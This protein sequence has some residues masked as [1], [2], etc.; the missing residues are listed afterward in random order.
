MKKDNPAIILNTKNPETLEPWWDEYSIPFNTA[1]TIADDEQYHSHKFFEI[2]FVESGKIKHLIEQEQDVLSE[3]DI[4]IIS[5]GIYHG[6]QRFSDVICSHRDIL[7]GKELLKSVCSY[8]SV[9]LYEAIL[10]RPYHRFHLSENEMYILNKY[11]NLFYENQ[12]SNDTKANQLQT[13]KFILS[14]IL[15]A[16]HL[17]LND[18][19]I[20]TPTNTIEQLYVKL[21]LI[22]LN[23]QSLDSALKEFHYN[24]SYLCR[25]FKSHSGLTMTEYVN[26]QKLN[27]AKNLLLFTSLPIKEIVIMLGFSS[28]AY[29]F[30]KF[31]SLFGTTPNHFRKSKS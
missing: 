25:L 17:S 4:F 20:P 14:L 26:Q 8:F 27:R 23:N 29:F 16:F 3:G 24:K 31:K 7:V 30:K 28:E 9:D 6:F 21:S 15:G 18:K 22:A 10:S 11:F 12:K 2:F 1:T 5:P 19:N 13:I